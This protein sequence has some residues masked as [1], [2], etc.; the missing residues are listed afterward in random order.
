MR[1]QL[2][3]I[4][5]GLPAA[6]LDGDLLTSKV[7]S[8]SEGDKPAISLSF[9]YPAATI[10]KR[11]QEEV[12]AE[13]AKEGLSHVAV[14]SS[15][16][17]ARR[18]AQGGAQR[19]DGAANIIAVA[20]AKGG[21][22]KSLVA[23]NLALALQAEGTRVGLLDADIHGPSIAMV[24]GGG[25]PLVDEQEQIVPLERHGIQVI[26]MGHLVDPDQAVIWRG[27]M[28]VKALR[29][30]LRETAWKDLD[31]LVLDLPP[32]TG[33]VQLSIAQ[34]TPVTGAI[35]VST[36]QALAL[37]DALRGVQMFAKLSIPVLG[38]VANMT[39]FI[40]PDCG[41]EHEIFGVGKAARLADQAGLELLATLPLNPQVADLQ[42]PAFA[43]NPNDAFAYA[44]RELAVRVGVSLLRRPVDRG[45]NIP[46]IVSS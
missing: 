25:Q 23:A 7:A 24:F 40:C 30:L 29:Q 33:D 22:G 1:E 34:S 46:E 2:E 21:V 13:L 10:G 17:I 39:S 5:R 28:V 31:F 8:V 19:I 42:K 26:S 37:A 11:A 12:R 45:A 20:S 15:T 32:G 14:S 44:F 27:P 41:S 43:A 4:L 16:K 6:H 36:P 9:P 18:L 38:Y 3:E 35:V